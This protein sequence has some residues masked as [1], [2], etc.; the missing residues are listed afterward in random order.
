MCRRRLEALN[1]GIE[2][3]KADMIQ[4]EPKRDPVRKKWV[5]WQILFALLLFRV[6]IYQSTF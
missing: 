5:F 1:Q 3:R 6:S 4:G 2:K